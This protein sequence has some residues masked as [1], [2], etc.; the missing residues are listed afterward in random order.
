MELALVPQRE[1]LLTRVM[2]SVRS[3][4]DDAFIDCP[5]SLGLLTVNAWTA[6]DAVLIPMQ[7]EYYALEGLSQLM[8]T[9]HPVRD[10]RNEIG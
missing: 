2:A 8:A 3:D 6:A 10:H 1:R 9:I 4:F 5:P 7:G